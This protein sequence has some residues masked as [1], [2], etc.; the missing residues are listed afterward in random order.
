MSSVRGQAHQDDRH[1]ETRRTLSQVSSSLD[2]RK[3]KKFRVFSP[4]YSL[5]DR[6][7]DQD[8]TLTFWIK[9][10][11]GHWVRG[12]KY[13]SILFLAQSMYNITY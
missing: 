3:A 2:K 1:E 10:I 7:W 11:L 5:G 9:K 4:L 6:E 8:P 12:C 13:I